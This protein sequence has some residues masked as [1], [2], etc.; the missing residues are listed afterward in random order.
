[1]NLNFQEYG[2]GRPLLIL[3]GLLGSLDNW[4]TLSKA[5]A[6][7]FRVLAVDQRNHGRSPHSDIFT[8]GAMAEDLVEFLDRLE[9]KSTIL[10]GHS[11]G[12]KTAMQVALSHP[13]RVEK[14]IVVDI[15]PRAY[16]PLHDELLE[17][18][19]SINLADYQSRQQVDKALETRVPEFPVRQFLLKNLSR[20]ASGEFSWKANLDVI[21]RNYKEIARQITAFDPFPKPALFVKGSRSGYIL[22]SDT[23][24]IRRLFPRSTISTIEAGHW[25]HA[26]SP[27]PFADLVRRFL[28]DA[29]D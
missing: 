13:E 29:A 15:S 24:A 19:Q 7:S 26:D 10:L 9:I 18:L 11:M 21:F 23:P 8:Y 2:K 4:H 16:P 25:I 20:D 28:K 17:A 22:D 3:H 12:G 14:L 6:T 1:M 5:F 27:E